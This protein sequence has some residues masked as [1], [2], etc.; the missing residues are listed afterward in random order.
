MKKIM[1]AFLISL[2]LLTRMTFA[3]ADLNATYVSKYIWR[4]FDLNA[5]QP[6]IQPGLTIGLGDSGT[7][8]GLWGSYNIG[9]G[10]RQLTELD[11]TLDYSLSVSGV[12]YSIGYTYYTFPNLTG[13][14]AKSGEFYAGATLGEVLFSPGL[15]IYYDHDQGDGVYASLSGGYDLAMISSSL[16]VGYNAGQWGAK[17]GSIDIALGLSSEISVGAATVTPSV[18]Y[19]LVSDTSVNPNSSEFWFGIDIAGSI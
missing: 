9:A 10:T 19:V 11:A 17:S 1:F 3:L 14:A 15:T 18:N 8:L 13:A 6:A 12:D 5:A 16:A 4:G 7:S 2:I